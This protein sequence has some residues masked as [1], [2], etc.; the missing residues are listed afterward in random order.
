MKLHIVLENGKEDIIKIKDAEITKK[1]LFNKYLNEYFD[2]E[3][4]YITIDGIKQTKAEN[5]GFTDWYEEDFDEENDELL[6]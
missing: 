6:E 2:I 1:D 4:W 5:F 3:E